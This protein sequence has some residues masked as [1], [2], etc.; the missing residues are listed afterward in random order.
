MTDDFL[1]VRPQNDSIYREEAVDAITLAVN[2][3]LID[4]NV[5]TS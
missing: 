4:K 2:L 1:Q 5:K 3:S